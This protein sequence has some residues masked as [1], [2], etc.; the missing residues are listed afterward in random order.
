LGNE[1][2]DRILADG[3]VS[4]LKR[5]GIRGHY[6]LG[7]NEVGNLNESYFSGFGSC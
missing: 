3:I 2:V 6:G 1:G 4:D 5:D 7:E